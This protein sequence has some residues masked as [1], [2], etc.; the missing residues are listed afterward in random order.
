MPPPLFRCFDA[1]AMLRYIYMPAT[2]DA[3]IRYDIRY[4]CCFSCYAA[5]LADYFAAIAL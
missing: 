2:A 4:C 3:A 5:M 1:F